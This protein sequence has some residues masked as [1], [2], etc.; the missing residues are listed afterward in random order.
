MKLL[1]YFCSCWHACRL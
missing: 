1:Y